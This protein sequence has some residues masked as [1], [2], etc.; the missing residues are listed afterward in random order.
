MTVSI[1]YHTPIGNN[2]EHVPPAMRMT[3]TRCGATGETVYL[4]FAFGG[5]KETNEI[6]VFGT[7]S[8]MYRF[9]RAAAAFN[10]AIAEHDMLAVPVGAKGTGIGRK[11]HAA[12][13]RLGH[14]LDAAIDPM[15]RALCESDGDA[16][17]YVR[18]AE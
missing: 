5:G 9:T 7:P 6:A 11:E 17:A 18:A 8:D 15:F 1:N 16:Q 14:K 4:T 2:W 10:A 13:D 12:T 3:A